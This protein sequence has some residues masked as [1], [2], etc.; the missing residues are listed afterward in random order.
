MG[1]EVARVLGPHP[2]A[3]ADRM[4]AAWGS[5]LS[6]FGPPQPQCPLGVLPT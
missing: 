5:R 2:P 1:W 6:P 3:H 4:L